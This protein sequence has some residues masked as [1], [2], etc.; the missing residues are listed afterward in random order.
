LDGAFSLFPNPASDWVNI[1]SAHGFQVDAL[2]LFSI[3]GRAVP[4]RTQDA[5]QRLSLEGLPPGAYL[6]QIVSGKAAVQ[7]RI[8]KQ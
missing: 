1:R 3:D 2:R 5:N 8:I 4:I 7:K 6:L